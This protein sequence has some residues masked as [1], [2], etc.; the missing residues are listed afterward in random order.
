MQQLLCTKPSALLLPREVPEAQVQLCHFGH[1]MVTFGSHLPPS[2]GI[3]AGSGAAGGPAR[4]GMNFKYHVTGCCLC[5]ISLSLFF[6]ASFSL[7][8]SA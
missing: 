6:K 3:S 4:V 1:R 7:C 5:L 8:K 2:P